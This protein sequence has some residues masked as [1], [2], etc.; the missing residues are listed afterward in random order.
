MI[1]DPPVLGGGALADCVSA[2]LCVLVCMCV[3]VCV[4]VCVCISVYV[5]QVDHLPSPSSFMENTIQHPNFKLFKPFA[6]NTIWP[7]NAITH[8]RS[9]DREWI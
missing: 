7:T 8:L 6:S 4:C 5:Y 2:T 3:C 9:A 1:F